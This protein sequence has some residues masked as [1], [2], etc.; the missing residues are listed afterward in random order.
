MRLEPAQFFPGSPVRLP[1]QRDCSLLLVPQLLL[2]L[3]VMNFSARSH[4]QES[5]WDSLTG[6]SALRV[7]V[8]V[9]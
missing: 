4:R 9:D 2:E 5:Q 7:A 6:A 1:L 3:K 8:L